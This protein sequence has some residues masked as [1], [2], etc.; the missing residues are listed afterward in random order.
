MNTRI[1][2]DGKPVEVSN[3]PQGL[4]EKDGIKNSV[5][6]PLPKRDETRANQDI[7]VLPY[8]HMFYDGEGYCKLI[9]KEEIPTAI[10]EKL[11]ELNK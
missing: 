1:A 7:Y 6:K 10:A 11:Y 3:I 5:V 2:S 9:K 4:S 8:W